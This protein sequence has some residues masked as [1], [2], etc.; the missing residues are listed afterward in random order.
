MKHFTRSFLK[1][2]F[3]AVLLSIQVPRLAAQTN[4]SPGVS[5]NK[6]PPSSAVSL[7]SPANVNVNPTAPIII[8]PV[9]APGTEGHPSALTLGQATNL[10]TPAQPMSRRE[11]ERAAYLLKGK[12]A[13]DRYEE[14]MQRMIFSRSDADFT[15]DTGEANLVK[16]MTR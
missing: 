1:I 12:S 15:S 14:Q 3:A 10:Q 2:G 13:S 5:P 7:V 9:A 16:F 11:Y 4:A 8:L 6:T